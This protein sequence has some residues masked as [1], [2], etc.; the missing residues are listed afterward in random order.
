M[1][2][3]INVVSK[4]FI[5]VLVIS[6]SDKVIVYIGHTMCST[7]LSDEEM[8]KIKFVDLEKLHNFVVDNFLI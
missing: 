7:A 8:T 2:I 5:I 6:S 1:D 4:I 3:I